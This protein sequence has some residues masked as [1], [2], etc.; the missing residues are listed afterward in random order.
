MLK[1][2]EMIQVWNNEISTLWEWTLDLHFFVEHFFF[3]ILRIV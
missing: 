1:C 3:Q 2:T